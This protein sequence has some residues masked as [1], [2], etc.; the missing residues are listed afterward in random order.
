MELQADDHFTKTKV[1]FCSLVQ[2]PETEVCLPF[3]PNW[4][5]KQL[6]ISFHYII[7]IKY[8]ILK[9]LRIKE[10]LPYWANIPDV[11]LWEKN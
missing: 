5:L 9:V 3:L 1:N 6:N 2:Q 7:E 11:K 8:V 4:Y 10:R